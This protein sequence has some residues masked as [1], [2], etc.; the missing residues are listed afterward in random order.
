MTKF[1]IEKDIAGIEGL[2]IIT[3]VPISDSRGDF[4]ETYNEQEFEKYDMKLHFVQENQSF[5]NKGDCIFRKSIHK[6]S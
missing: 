3:P 4:M 2:A 1:I 5:S 6:A